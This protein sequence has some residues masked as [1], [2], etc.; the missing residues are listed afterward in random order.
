MKITTIFKVIQIVTT[1]E[2]DRFGNSCVYFDS[3][4]KMEKYIKQNDTNHPCISWYI[5]KET[6]SQYFVK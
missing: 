3:E 2:G 4:E 6:A 5:Q 1:P